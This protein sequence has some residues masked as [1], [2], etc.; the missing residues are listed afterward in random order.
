[1]IVPK[2]RKHWGINLTNH[3]WD[4]YARKY[5]MLMKLEKA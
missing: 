2:N 5:K 3:V 1:M 4:L